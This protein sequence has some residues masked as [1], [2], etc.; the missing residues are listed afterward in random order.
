MEAENI[1]I[2]E[3]VLETLNN[4]FSGLF[5][6]IDNSIYP[7]LDDLA[8]INIDILNNSPLE[9]ILGTSTQNGI[10][11]ICNSCLVGFLL[12]FFISNFISF[13]TFSNYQKPLSFFF[14]LILYGIL[15]NCSFFFC[16]QIINL[17]SLLS[18]SIRSLGETLFGNS[19]CFA[20]LIEKLNSIIS[21]GDTSFNIF[22]LDGL[23]K[24]FISFGLFQLVF[25]YSFRYVLIKVWI[26]ISPFAI[27][28]LILNTTSCFFRT[29]FRSFIAFML[30]Q[31]FIS[32]I[33]LIAFSVNY[34]DSL[35]GKLTIVGCIY[36]F[37]KA[38]SIVKEWIGGISSDV[39]TGIAGVKSILKGGN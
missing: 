35:V 23:I 8:F 19:I 20:S 16:E 18:S 25:T 24:G 2:T 21:V 5:S 6:S 3:V 34:N 31:V 13:Y 27:M 15:M 1:N 38:N 32:F 9:N 14:K 28:S 39:S 29:W 37:T 17:I 4:L 36:A 12:Y 26:L 11:L 10:L 22:S 7:V 33:L 30:V